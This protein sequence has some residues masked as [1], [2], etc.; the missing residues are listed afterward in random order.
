MIRV[1]Y[2][3]DEVSMAT[4]VQAVFEATAKDCALEVVENGRRCLERMAET[5][6]DV[7]MVDLLMP[8]LNGLEVLGELAARRDPTPVI[9][10]SG[11]GQ[12]DLAVKALRAG[13]VDCIDKVSSEFRNIA[14]IVRRVHAHNLEHQPARRVPI[15]PGEAAQ[16]LYLDASEA[17]RAHM[18]QFFRKYAKA[19]AVET[20]SPLDFDRY[21]TRPQKFAALVIGSELDGT[22]PLLLLRKLHSHTDD[23]P[24]IVISSQ[25]DGEKAIAAFNLG[26]H[27]FLVQKDGFLSELIFSLNNALKH[28]ESARLNA[29]LTHELA[30]LNR[31]LE[32]Q[33]TA[34]TAELQALSAR[35]LR[36]QEDER[37]FLARELHDQFGQVLTGLKFQLESA[38][39]VLPADP[40]L[41]EAFLLAD[42][43]LRHVRAL[44]LQLRPHI[45]DDLGLQ[46]ALEWHLNLFQRQTKIAVNAEYT[47]PDR[48]LPGELETTIFRIVQEALTNVARHSGSSA[49]HVTVAVDERH[50]LVEITDR[51]RGFDSERVLA[52]HESVGLAGLVDRVNLAGGRAEIFSRVGQGTRVHAEFPLAV[53]ALSATS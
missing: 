53:P 13:A 27:D 45:L 19:L 16:I 44:T 9:M 31:S 30:E 29:R 48:R 43:L 20:V 1:L 4:M 15:V 26:A 7:V 38:R 51:G 17:G 50:A 33:V 40:A 36:V 6:F 22:D 14:D 21:L 42:E 2:A 39:R 18:A 35:L 46:P 24:A 52:L 32:A 34:R 41:G 47:L 37:R 12:T 5:K 25:A 49:A 3:E 11:R 23:V 10:V 28:A 8:E